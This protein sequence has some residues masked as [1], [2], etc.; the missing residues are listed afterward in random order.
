MRRI[1]KNTQVSPHDMRYARGT[2]MAE[3][4]LKGALA[5][6]KKRSKGKMDKKLAETIFTNALQPVANKLGHVSNGKPNINMT[7]R[8]YI[9]PKLTSGY[10]RE[11]NIE[12][13]RVVEKALGDL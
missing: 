3:P 4:A 10:F 2:E 12:P 8:G 1:M 13:P 7:I 9:H 6:Y 5:D 11:L